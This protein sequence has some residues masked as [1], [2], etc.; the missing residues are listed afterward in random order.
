MSEYILRYLRTRIERLGSE[1]Q[2][3]EVRACINELRNLI[4]IVGNYSDSSAERHVAKH[5][6]LEK[7]IRLN[8]A[9]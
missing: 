2:T 3:A 7:I 8:E 6:G 5:A 4:L 9:E 1:P